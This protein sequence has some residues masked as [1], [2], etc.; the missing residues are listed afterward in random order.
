MINKTDYVEKRA[1]LKKLA[2]L[3]L[4]VKHLRLDKKK[5]V[6]QDFSYDAIFLF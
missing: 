2:N 1:A 4:K 3:K 6:K 5:E